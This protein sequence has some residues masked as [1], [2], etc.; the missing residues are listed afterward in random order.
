MLLTHPFVKK[1]ELQPCSVS[2]LLQGLVV[3]PKSLPPHWSSHLV[4]H[5]C[6]GHIPALSVALALLECMT[7]CR[8]LSS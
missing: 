2:T 5:F 1:S 8:C 3:W 6:G 4:S 7:E